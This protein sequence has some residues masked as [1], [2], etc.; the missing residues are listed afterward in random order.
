MPSEEERE[1]W[2]EM[3]PDHNQGL[4]LGPQSGLVAVD[5]DT[6]DEKII[7]AIMAVLPKSPWKRVG[8]KGMV[9]IYK[10]IDNAT[11]R[12]R[13][14]NEKT[15]VEILSRGTQIVIPPSIHPDTQ[16]PYW[17]NCELVGC[18][19]DAPVLPKDSDVL[20]RGALTDCGVKI[21]KRS[22]VSITQFVPAGYRDNAMV[23]HSGLLA[24]AVWRGERSLLETFEM[25]RAWVENYTENVIG[26][27][28]SVDKGCQKIVEFL[29]RDVGDKRKTLPVG[30]DEGLT[31][32]MKKA[33]GVDFSDENLQW[34]YSRLTE[35][36]EANLL[37]MSSAKENGDGQIHECSR[38]P[39]GEDRSIARVVGVRKGIGFKK[40]CASLWQAVYGRFPP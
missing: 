35:Y 38:V 18:L 40:D 29:V 39:A 23:A 2:A 7:A 27:S 25:M 20:I 8:K 12:I 31:E 14:E 1:L 37:P 32:E 10:W 6:D 15:V 36:V 21:A 5:I 17:S 28:M 33:Y 3:Y 19:Q 34:D 13:D 11:A 4:P 22:K 30:W 26:D 24:T 9:L 16:K